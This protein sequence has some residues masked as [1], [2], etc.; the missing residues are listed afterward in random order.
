[1][2]PRLLLLLLLLV[3]AAPLRA[4]DQADIAAVRQADDS[5]T[6]AM[7][8]S[9]DQGARF[10]ALFSDELQYRHSSG[11]VDTKAS[12]IAALTAGHTKYTA[13]KIEERKFLVAAP[14]I[15]LITGRETMDESRDGTP[16]SLHLNFLGVWRNENGAWRFLAWQSCKLTP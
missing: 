16:Q 1:M 11:H 12:Y 10:R 5:R 2:P 3:L 7:L 14:G 4:D 13:I 6:A 8:A 15:V 9:G